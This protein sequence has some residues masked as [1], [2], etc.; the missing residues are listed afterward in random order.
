MYVAGNKVHL[1]KGDRQSIGYKRSDLDFKFT[2][3]T[4]PIDRRYCIYL[5][6]DGLADQ[7]GGPQRLS[8]G[9]RRLQSL[10]LEY[11]QQPF[12]VQ[13]DKILKAMADYQ[14]DCVRQDD[15]TLIGFAVS[16]DSLAFA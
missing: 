3:H 2:N 4:L 8:F 1:I 6:S 16:P 13:K 11:S 5:A 10:L 7:R 14:R 12:A 9:N 15:V